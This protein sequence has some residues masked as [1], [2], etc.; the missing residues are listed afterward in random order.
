MTKNI[1]TIAK[2]EATTYPN[3]VT[4]TANTG[5]ALDKD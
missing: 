4:L 5:I 1:F 3:V 2:K